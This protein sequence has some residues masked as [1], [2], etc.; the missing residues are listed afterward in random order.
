MDFADVVFPT[1]TPYETDVP[2]EAG[3]GWLMARTKVIEPLG[4]Y[5]SIYELILD[6]GV[7]MGYGEDFW[8]GDMTACMNDQLSPFGMTIDDLRQH[9]LGLTY[10]MRPATYENYP[11]IFQG[12]LSAP[13]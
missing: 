11:G 9:P 10:P 6:L 12:P 13:G 4:D 8:N 2:F 7:A 5:K 3:D 1:T